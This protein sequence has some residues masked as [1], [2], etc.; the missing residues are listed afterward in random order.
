[1]PVILGRADFGRWLDPAVSVEDLTP[2]LR[3]C[4]ADVLEKFPNGPLVNSP[5]HAGQ[6]LLPPISASPAPGS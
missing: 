2:L 5:R 6:E 4:P 3:P 1:M